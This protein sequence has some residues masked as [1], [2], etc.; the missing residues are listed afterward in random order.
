M[1]TIGPGVQEIRITDQSGIYRVIYV[2][3]FEDAVYV[4]HCF[5]KRTQKTPS[6]DLGIA[7]DRYGS[8]VERLKRHK[9][10]ERKGKRK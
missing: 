3:K 4:L 10:E 5:Q 6:G 9:A 2:A 8:L 7:K 1:K